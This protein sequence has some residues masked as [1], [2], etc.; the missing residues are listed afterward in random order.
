MLSKKRR[1]LDPEWLV[2]MNGAASLASA[3]PHDAS[4]PAHRERARQLRLA[5][6]KPDTV[7]ENGNLNP[8]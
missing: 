5:L 6:C 1:R 7:L 3:I 4:T 8:E 2:A